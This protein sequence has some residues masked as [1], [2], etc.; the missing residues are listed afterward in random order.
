MEELYIVVE[1]Q[2]NGDEVANI[3]TDYSSEA[4]AYY[5]F[6][7]ASAFAAISEVDKHAISLLN[8]SGGLIDRSIFIHADLGEDEEYNEPSKY[9]VI[10]YQ[11]NNGQPTKIVTAHDTLQDAEYKFHTTAAVASISNVSKHIVIALNDDGFPVE[12]AIFTH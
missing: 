5:N 12:Y 9:I 4:N 10:E 8:A 1:L 2:R 11:I 3:V 6:H 7:Y